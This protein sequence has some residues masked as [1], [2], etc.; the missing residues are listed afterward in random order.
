MKPNRPDEPISNEERRVSDAVRGLSTPV[1]DP[2]FRARLRRDFVTGRFEKPMPVRTPWFVRPFVWLPIAA[3]AAL[4]LTLT[5][6]GPDW[7]VVSSEGEGRVIVSGQAFASSDRAGIAKAIARGGEIA[8]EGDVT[9]DLVAKGSVAVALAPE[10]RMTLP[11]APARWWSRHA[12]ATIANGDVYFSTGRRFHGATLDVL[13]PTVAARCVGTS[14]AV[15][16]SPVLGTCVCVM[17]GKVNVAKRE[18]GPG[19]GVEV[20]SGMRR[21]VNPQGGETTETILEDSVHHLH[22]QLSTVSDQL[23][24]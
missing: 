22:H 2:A 5:N 8:I 10:T 11:A 19:V 7:N 1:A 9:L 18:L 3:A 4:V 24:R 6:Q 17:E 23:E 12:V 21:F 14:F 16:L 13:T 15:L 20:P